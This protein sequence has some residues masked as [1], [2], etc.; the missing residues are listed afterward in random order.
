MHLTIL[1]NMWAFCS[2]IIV[3]FTCLGLSVSSAVAAPKPNVV[4]FM[5]DDM[6]IGDTSA[7]LGLDPAGVGTVNVAMNTPNLDQLAR[8]GM[9]FTDAHTPATMCSAT[10]YGVLTGRHSYRTFLKARGWLRHDL[11]QPMIEPQRST[12]GTL[13][14][15][16]GYRTAAIGKWH[17]GMSSVDQNGHITSNFG[18]IDYTAPFVDAPTDHGFDYYFGIR[19]NA[20]YDVHIEN[21]RWV[22]MDRQ[23]ITD[24]NHRGSP[25]FWNQ[26]KLD[27]RHLNSALDFI[28][29]HLQNHE[30]QPFFMYYAPLSNHTPYDPPDDLNGEPIAGEGM[31]RDMDGNLTR[32]SSSPITLN[33]RSDHVYQND[34]ALGQLINKLQDPDG[35]GDTSDSVLEDTMIVFTSDNGSDKLGESN[36]GMRGRKAFLWEAGHR[37]P[38]IV[39]W[40][41]TIE[42]GSVNTDTISLIDTYATLAELTG[43]SLE[44]TNAEDSTSFLPALHGQPL[45]PRPSMVTF[46]HHTLQAKLDDSSAKPLVDRETWGWLSIRDGDWKLL[47][48]DNLI[49]P[50]RS[51]DSNMGTPVPRHLY[52][53]A[54]HPTEQQDLVNDPAYASLISDLLDK[55]VRY[56]NQGYTRH[57]NLNQPGSLIQHDGEAELFN[58]RDGAIGYEFT[59]GPRDVIAES[60]G[61]WDDGA[62]DAANQGDATTDGTSDGLATSHVIRLFDTATQTEIASLTMAA[63]TDPSSFV[64]GEFRFLDLPQNLTLQAGQTYALTMSTTAGDSDLFHHFQPHTGTSPLALN[65]VDDF[66]AAAANTDGNYPSDLTGNPDTH[67]HRLLVG[68]SA[69]LDWTPLDFNWDG[70]GDGD[71]TEDRWNHPELHP[72]ST[73]TAT[74][75]T[76]VVTVTGIQRA[77]STDV[78]SGV[79]HLRGVLESP[80]VDIQSGAAISI[81]NAPTLA[82]SLEIH[83]GGIFEIADPSE[84]LTVTDSVQLDPDSSLQLASDFQ[85]DRG[86][87]SG[88]FSLL[89]ADQSITGSFANSPGELL[90]EDGQFLSS[91]ATESHTIMVD[92]VSAQ[93]GDTDG[94]SDIDMTDFN[95]LSSNFDPTGIGGP[96]GWQ[97]GDFDGNQLI[98]VTDF[99]LLS[100][101]FSPHGYASQWGSSVA[102]PEPAGIWHVVGL[103]MTILCF[104]RQHPGRI[105]GPSSAKKTV[106]FIPCILVLCGSLNGLATSFVWADELDDIGY[107]KLADELGT[108]MPDGTGISVGIVEAKSEN[109]SQYRPDKNH[110]RFP[111]KNFVF[112]SGGSLTPSNH[113]TTVGIYFFGTYNIAPGIT[114]IHSWEADHWQ[115][116]GFLKDGTNMEP[117]V[118]TQRI[119]NHSW[120]STDSD[121]GVLR[122]LDYV[123]NRD[124]LVVVVGQNNGNTTVLPKLLG[125]NYNT[126]SVGRT[127]GI[128]S[129]GF[130]TDDGAGRVKPEIVAPTP[131]TSFSSPT[132][133][134]SAAV[135]LE[136]AGDL[137]LVNAEENETVRALLL[138]GATKLEFLDQWNRTSSQPLDDHFGAGELN[139]YR[140]YQILTAG[141]QTASNIT[142]VAATGWDFHTTASNSQYFFEVPTGQQLAELS[143]V[144]VWNRQI[145]D[146]AGGGFS[147]TP[148]TL[149]NLDLKLHTANNFSLDTELDASVSTIDNVEHI[150]FNA[151]GI[152]STLGPGR[153]AL[154]VVSP[155]SG[156]DYALAWLGQLVEPHSWVS[157]D[158]HATW[159]DPNN[160]DAAG[161]PDQDWMVD[162]TNTNATTGQHVLL[163]S[164]AESYMTT[165]NGT[166]GTL[167]LEIPSGLTF[168]VESQLSVGPQAQLTGGGTIDGF[169]DLDGSHSIGQ[170]ET[171]TVTQFADITGASLTVEETYSQTM[172][173]TTGLFTS[174]YTNDLTGT[175]STPADAGAASHLGNGH[176][177]HDSV[178]SNEQV[179]V[180]IFAALLGDSDGDAD[181]DVTDFSVLSANFDPTGANPG[182]NWTQGDF[183]GN[184]LIDITDFT[185][186]SAS[187]SPD[188]YV[189]TVTAATGDAALAEIPEPSAYRLATIA[190]LV[191]LTWVLT[192][193][194]SRQPMRT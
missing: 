162:L 67:Q 53:L 145:V 117:L 64:D 158:P 134:A 92:I 86:T 30:N 22:D 147:P 12:V 35:N 29:D 50:Y 44:S 52:N 8:D 161:T 185:L 144:L 136:T 165:L 178:Y 98:D 155:A 157:S 45:G 10:R 34:R 180:D 80:T 187:F 66:V 174:L 130:T 68:P 21:N 103:L 40:A 126:I 159:S 99:N 146:G 48:D 71:W 110:I 128:H 43:Q 160:W 58:D 95:T 140:S 176:F 90:R 49:N 57:T 82:G 79:L 19:A 2:A 74:I 41:G 184:G 102:V 150:Y 27:E 83:S 192:S 142:D 28:D 85:I 46:S 31:L 133:G 173:T 177:L 60:L 114:D 107:R 26:K 156:V 190:L 151:Q 55:L 111:D 121:V 137:G 186:L 97:Q 18:S 123:I 33:L 3:A 179:Q 181:V 116:N 54:T 183:D 152:G 15:D 96:Q 84:T 5:A 167:T 23:L 25:G 175:F 7:Y 153:Y 164:D 11:D 113:A 122:R 120:I 61:M 77:Q 24:K 9:V 87:S 73:D 62:A 88:P 20:V 47:V 37:V 143:A 63:G 4:F 108:A 170:N 168:E 129:H 38:M 132:V 78:Q 76:D 194:D 141:E 16:A 119:V 125:Q 171:L 32:P 189:V 100:L 135:L 36:I 17:I 14:Q 105:Q 163:T 148:V 191:T 39:K 193:R 182:N 104:I 115:G 149:D 6:G 154:E 166:A 69:K 13:M 89:T 188:G 59:V 91:L 101:H 94:D 127:D 65:L 118:E 138:A 56:H 72:L 93:F 169:L 51:P 124:N 81:S 1:T 131:A 139:L 106:F 172:A 70:Q 109:T 42:E 112:K 75:Q